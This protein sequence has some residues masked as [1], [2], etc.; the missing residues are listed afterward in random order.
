MAYDTD[1]SS[2][3]FR[4]KYEQFLRACG[5]A[6]AE[7][8]WDTAERGGMEGY[9]F[10]ILLGVLLHLII[11]DGNVAER[12]VEYLNRNFGFD[13]TVE[14]LLEVYYSVGEEIEENYLENAKE[15]VALLEAADP[16]LADGFR[17]L[18]GLICEILAE[19][20]E[21]ISETELAELRTVAENL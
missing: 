21:G 20:D 15:G 4:Q 12:E 1:R 13:Y 6:E 5:A 10:G 7:G 14:S 2:E 19:S 17:D 3:E 8:R 11:S 9:C 16:A 18:L